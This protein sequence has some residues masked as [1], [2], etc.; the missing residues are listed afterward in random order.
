M[1]TSENERH[2]RRCMRMIKASADGYLNGDLSLFNV[3]ADIQELS[4]DVEQ[5]MLNDKVTETK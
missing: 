2:I 4:K 3:L 1:L 5:F